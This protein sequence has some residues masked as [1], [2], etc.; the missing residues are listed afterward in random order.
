[1]RSVND[2]GLRLVQVYGS[3]ETCP[4]AAYVR[5]ENAERK[6][7]AAGLAALHCD[8][9][10]VDGEDRDVAPGQ[11]GEII[12][13]GPNVS[14]G[15][16]RAPA[17]TAQAFRGGWYHSNDI[18]HFD[19]EGYLTVVGRKTDMII[20]GGENVYPAELENILLECSAILEACIV[21]RPDERWGE[22]LVAIVVLQSGARMS[23]ADVL[24]LFD[25][26][27]ARY[28]QPREVR[29]TDTLPRTALGKVMRT[30]VLKAIS[31]SVE[32]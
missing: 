21:G 11:D 32:A 17:I 1:V 13:R 8:V 5:A 20:S 10:V 16:W 19:D 6:A 29:F 22:A 9:R 2:C 23:E 7:G 12:V 28:K 26:R 27:I 15:Y 30:E 25:D 18:G 14:R 3:T 24:A 31:A 4:I